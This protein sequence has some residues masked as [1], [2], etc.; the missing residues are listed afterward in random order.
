M[1]EVFALF[2]MCYPSHCF[3]NEVLWHDTEPMAYGMTLSQKDV[4]ELMA[5][6]VLAKAGQD[7]PHAPGPNS[8]ARDEKNRS[9][10]R[11]R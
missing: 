5:L 8:S 3:L 9:S 11:S 10:G 1:G 4:A 2:L 7:D 6:D